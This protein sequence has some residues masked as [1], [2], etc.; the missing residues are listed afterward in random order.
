VFVKRADKN[1]KQL[2]K[3]RKQSSKSRKEVL[4]SKSRE[5]S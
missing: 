1:S 2:V 4:V 5:N 3:S